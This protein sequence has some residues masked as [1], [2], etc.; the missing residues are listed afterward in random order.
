VIFATSVLGSAFLPAYVCAVWWRKANT[1]GALS[2]M[3]M[4]ALVSFLWE[5]L[6]LVETT[7]LAPMLTGVVSSTVTMIVVSLMTQKSHPVPTNILA[8][9]RETAMIGPVSKQFLTVADATLTNEAAVIENMRNGD[10][11][12]D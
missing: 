11:R 8:A 4:G 9:M 1:P 6:S 12:H 3:I 7:Q 10:T 2:S 5:F